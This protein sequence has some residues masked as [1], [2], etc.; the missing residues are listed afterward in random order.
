MKKL[1]NCLEARAR[2]PWTRLAEPVLIAFALG[3]SQSLKL[4]LFWCS[5]LIKGLN[6][7]EFTED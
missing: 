1:R 6:H 3:L 2:A 5:L 4:V 7:V